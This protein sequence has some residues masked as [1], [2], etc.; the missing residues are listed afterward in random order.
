MNYALILVLF[1][2]TI[3]FATKIL[4]C[5]KWIKLEGNSKDWLSENCL[6]HCSH[7]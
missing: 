4:K 2:I 3:G 7:L 1:A 5:Q 6:A